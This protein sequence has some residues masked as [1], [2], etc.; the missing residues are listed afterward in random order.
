LTDALERRAPHTRDVIKHV[1]TL[2]TGSVGPP[3]VCLTTACPFW[4]GHSALCLIESQRSTSAETA[5]EST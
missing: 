3:A 1:C 5:R 2:R 4:R